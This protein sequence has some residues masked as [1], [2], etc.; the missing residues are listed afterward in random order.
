MKKKIQFLIGFIKSL[1]CED[2]S[3]T[4]DIEGDDIQYI[5]TPY[6]KGKSG[7]ISL[8]SNVESIVN[9]IVNHYTD[10]LYELGPGSAGDNCASDYYNVELTFDPEENK[11]V[12]DEITHTEYETESTGT[13][14]HISD[15]TE[16]NRMYNTFM[17]VRNFLEHKGIEEMTISYE[18]SGDSGSVNHEY[19]S[20]NGSG[21]IN[22]AIENICYDLLREYGGWEINEG[23]QGTIDFTKD[24]IT[25]NH[26][27]NTEESYTSDEIIEVNPEDF[28]E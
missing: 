21:E 12:F 25:V 3:I 24:E 26:E 10:E 13:S 4:I 8:P 17:T 5:N 19:N 9:E 15:Y 23:S 22:T 16:G 27:W 11:L 18:G 6:C 14:H 2:F 7:K 1:K 20:Q 28:N